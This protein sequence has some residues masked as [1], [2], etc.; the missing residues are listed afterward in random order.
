MSRSN[1]TEPTARLMIAALRRFEGSLQH[2]LHRDGFEDVSVALTNILRH[3]DRDGMRLQALAADAR[4]T[5]QAASQAVRALE[6]RGLVQVE[7]DPDDGRAKRV[8]YTGRGRRLI[9]RA[10]RHVATMERD[11]SRR[12][13]A[14]A[15]QS[16]RR[17]LQR[18]AADEDA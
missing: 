17:A 6:E 12:L 1:R 11:W 5:K 4:V 16:L 9:D 7:P 14:E 10:T 3:L 13:G 15:Y 18:L 8:V 2:K